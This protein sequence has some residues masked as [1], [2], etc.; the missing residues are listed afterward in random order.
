MQSGY[1]CIVFKAG[2]VGNFALG[3]ASSGEQEEEFDIIQEQCRQGTFNLKLGHLSPHH[4]GFSSY[5]S[6]S[7]VMIIICSP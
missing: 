7:T 5:L 1:F 4:M 6:A 2:N 3:N